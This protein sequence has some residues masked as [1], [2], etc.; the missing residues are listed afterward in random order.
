MGNSSFGLGNWNIDYVV[1]DGSMLWNPS[2]E[3]IKVNDFFQTFDIKDN[4]ITITT[5]LSSRG[6]GFGQ[7]IWS[8]WPE[9]LIA[10]Q[11]FSSTKDIAE[12]AHVISNRIKDWRKPKEPDMPV[13]IVEN[14]RSFLD[15]MLRRERWSASELADLT[16]ISKETA[17][18]F[19]HACGYTYDSHRAQFFVSNETPQ[20]IDMLNNVTWRQGR[21]D[22]LGNE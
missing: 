13:L 17:I 7:E 20:I 11:V 15:V 19:L 22:N 2:N 21:W 18:H 14:A 5:G 6:G 4:S 8:Y 1:S 9:I 10:L 12:V 3:E 16:G